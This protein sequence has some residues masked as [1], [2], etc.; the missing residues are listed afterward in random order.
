MTNEVSLFIKRGHTGFCFSV[1]KKQPPIERDMST[2]LQTFKDPGP[3]LDN[4]IYSQQVEG[5]PHFQSD[6]S[7]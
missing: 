2:W 1:D 4:I 3:F 6:P 5:V 7:Q